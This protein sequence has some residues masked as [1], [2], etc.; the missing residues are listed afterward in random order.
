MGFVQQM[1]L[2]HNAPFSSEEI[3]NYRRLI[4]NNITFGLRFLLEAM[5]DMELEVASDNVKYLEILA[6][7]ADLSDREPFPVHYLEPLKS[8]W[9]D[10]NVQKVYS[11][12]NELG[13]PEK[14]VSFVK[15]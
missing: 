13:L 12:I 15:A 14:W 3:E 11:K 4:F 7:V 5:G 6:E 9:E 10:V 2:A 1:R 8:L